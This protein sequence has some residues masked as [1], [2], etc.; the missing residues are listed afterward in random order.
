MIKSILLT[1]ILAITISSVASIPYASAGTPTLDGAIGVAE[2]AN[3]VL[4]D[5][6][7]DLGGVYDPGTSGSFAGGQISGQHSDWILYWDFDATNIYFAADP[8]GSTAAGATGATEIGVH[9]LPTT[10]DPNTGVGTTDCTGTFFSLLA[11]NSYFSFTCNFLGDFT[12]TFSDA[13]PTPLSAG[14][15]FVQGAVTTTL[16]P[17]EWNLVRT[18]LVRPGDTTY[19]GDLQCLWFRASAFDSRSVDNG[20]GPGARTIWLKLDPNTPNCGETIQVE[21]DIKPG[22]DPSSVNCKNTEGSVPVAVF[23]S[24]NFVVSTIDL[25]SLQ[26]NGVAVTEEHDTIHIEDKNGDEFPDAVLHL[27]KIG[28]CEATSDEAKYPLKETAD[29]TLTGSNADGDFEGIGDIRIVKR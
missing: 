3:S 8:L 5:R 12:F 9:F 25:N 11:H 15:M 10:G 20:A 19:T 14:E 7:P 18:D 13:G 22:S 17:I 16:L 27:D 28:V 6:T 2:Y 21:I 1:T 24:A 23:G 4:V 29:A 26:L